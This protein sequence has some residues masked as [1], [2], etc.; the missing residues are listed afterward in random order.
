MNTDTPIA[1]GPEH[2]L[3]SPQ[4]PPHVSAPENGRTPASADILILSDGRIFVH[5]LTPALA[6]VLLELNPQDE[7]AMARAKAHA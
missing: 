6:A 2:G 7:L 1:T 4:Q 5:N 3:P